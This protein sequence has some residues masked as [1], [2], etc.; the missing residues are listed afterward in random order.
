MYRGVEGWKLLKNAIKHE[1]IMPIR[2]ENS[3]SW[4]YKHLSPSPV[5]RAGE[6][7]KVFKP[8]KMLS[9]FN[10]IELMISLIVVS[11]IAASFAPVISKRL[12][13]GNVIAGGGLGTSGSS[14]EMLLFASRCSDYGDE[15]KMC[16]AEKCLLCVKTCVAGEGL[17]TSTCECQDCTANFGAQ[18]LQCKDGRCTRCTAGYYPNNGVCTPCPAGKYSAEGSSSC[19]QCP[20]GKYSTEGSS[21]CSNCT[22]GYSCSAGSSSPTQNTCTPGTCSDAGASSCSPCSGG[23]YCPD[24][25]T[26]CGDSLHVLDCG[27]GTCSNA[28]ASS[29]SQCPAGKY[30]PDAGA[31][32]GIPSEAINCGSGTC[33]NAGASSCS[34]CPAGKYCPDA[35]TVCAGASNCESGTCSDLGASSCSPCPA[36]KYCP[37]TATA[38]AS[39]SSCSNGYY[40]GPGSTSCTQSTTVENCKTYSKTT[41]ACAECNAGYQPS[42]GACVSW[43]CSGD[44]FIKIGENLCATKKNM[45]DS[46]NLA[47]SGASVKSGG[48]SCS[49][50]C[51]WKGNTSSGTCNSTNS[52]Y[53]GCNR[54]VCNWA[55]GNAACA[56]FHAGGKIWR[57]PT[58]AEMKFFPEKSFGLGNNGLRLCNLANGSDPYCSG[59]SNCIGSE[60]N[61]CSPFS[62]HMAKFQSNQC[63]GVC[64]ITSSTSCSF[65]GLCNSA[66]SGLG[67]GSASI[68]CVAEIC[69]QGYEY[70][71]GACVPWTCSGADFMQIGSLCVTK[72][73]MGDSINLVFPD[74]VASHGYV[75]SSYCAGASSACCWKADKIDEY[76]NLNCTAKN[77]SYSGCERTVCN[78]NAANKICANFHA[79]GKTWRLPSYTEMSGWGAKSTGKGN[80]GLMLCNDGGYDVTD[81]AKCGQSAY[82]QGAQGNCTPAAVWAKDN[83]QGYSSTKYVYRMTG[84]TASWSSSYQAVNT[85]AS[86][87]CVTEM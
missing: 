42:D 60:Y 45:G 41:D 39:A 27:S 44:D 46:T 5:E 64:D 56:S 48:T 59:G 65:T 68:R 76:G 80:N 78:W 22:A 52:S 75:M 23:K 86:V 35:G 84:G 19:S 32:C 4:E 30:C 67:N 2:K 40:S 77:G 66:A 85:P 28:G 62:L 55:G 50:K 24:S 87:R 61:T 81:Y 13:T 12:K 38:C 57:L 79:G 18:C 34:Q 43:P 1:G 53:S 26:N 83:Y 54:T 10:L 36:G 15:C 72:R 70:S 47:I 82:C 49:G 7:V 21:S 63:I 17:N 29:C 69:P 73:N 9:A 11:M 37:D 31:D 6:R 16:T 51:C 71:D 74:S 8:L 3:L 25:A 14:G 33:S 58:M 20:A